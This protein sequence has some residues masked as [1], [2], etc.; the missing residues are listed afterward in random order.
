MKTLTVRPIV[1]I[2]LIYIIYLHRRYWVL[3]VF[4]GFQWLRIKNYYCLLVWNQLRNRE[5][6][7]NVSSIIEKADQRTGLIC[8]TTVSLLI[9]SNT[10]QLDG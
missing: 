5:D 8:V 3:P 2:I 1:I 9:P 7:Q 4:E 10:P 6:N